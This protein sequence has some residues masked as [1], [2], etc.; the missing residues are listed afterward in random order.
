MF[1][2]RHYVNA[3]N[4]Y[5]MTYVS[6]SIKNFNMNSAMRVINLFT[7]FFDHS[8]R[9]YIDVVLVD[10]EEAKYEFCIVTPIVRGFPMHKR[11]ICNIP[12]LIRIQSNPI[13]GR[14]STNP[15]FSLYPIH[16]AASNR[17]DIRT[18]QKNSCEW[19]QILSPN[20]WNVKS[21][22][23]NSHPGQNDVTVV[24]TENGS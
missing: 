23:G 12:Y 19:A 10:I 9:G 6:H 21:H 20:G 15:R 3:I 11:F 5:T 22:L 16:R 13:I 8:W 2:F 4:L 1:K 18:R 7:L 14:P 17:V 24:S